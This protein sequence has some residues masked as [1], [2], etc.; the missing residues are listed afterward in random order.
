MDGDKVY[1]VGFSEAKARCG[2][3]M[4]RDRVRLCPE[5]M[6]VEQQFGKGDDSNVLRE[7]GIPPG[8]RRCLVEATKGA[9]GK[10]RETATRRCTI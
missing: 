3:E 7:I 5:M 4:T 1:I 6:W 2:C 9:G 8:W 10:P